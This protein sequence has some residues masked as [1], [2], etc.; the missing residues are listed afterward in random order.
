MLFQSPNS[1][2]G[3]NNKNRTAIYLYTPRPGTSPASPVGPTGRRLRPRVESRQR[4]GIADHRNHQPAQHH[5]RRPG[6]LQLQRQTDRRRPDLLAGR[7]R[8]RPRQAAAAEHRPGRRK[9]LLPARQQRRRQPR[10]HP[11]ALRAAARGPDAAE[12]DIYDAHSGGG[13][14]AAEPEPPI[15]EGEACRTTTSPKPEAAAPT[16]PNFSGAGNSHRSGSS[17]NTDNTRRST[18][19]RSTKE[20]D[21]KRN[22]KTMRHGASS[23]PVVLAFSLRLGSRHSAPPAPRPISA[24]NRSASPISTRTPRNRPRRPASTRT[25]SSTF[26]DESDDRQ[27]GGAPV[28]D[29]QPKNIQTELPAGFYG[30]PEA[31]PFCT[32]AYLIAN[33]G[34]CNPAAQVGDPRALDRPGDRAS[35]STCRSTTWQRPTKKPR[36]LPATSSAPWSR[37]FSR[38]APTAITDCGRYPRHQSGPPALGVKTD[39]LGGA[40]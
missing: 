16:T 7:L 21:G 13:F 24:S 27:P 15:C 34:L 38:S 25:S 12:L 22:G 6:L 40:R 29:G 36:C 19:R 10:L 4:A 30:N 2:D 26:D 28:T 20:E 39:P 35:I 1:I 5:Q 33:G 23:E 8:V 31:I 11:L 9:P 37:S 14:A 32:S 17:R 3:A 18:T